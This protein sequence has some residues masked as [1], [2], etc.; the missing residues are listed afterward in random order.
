MDR[1]FWLVFCKRGKI[2]D[3]SAIHDSSQK[4]V[5]TIAYSLATYHLVPGLREKKYRSTTE[6]FYRYY[7]W[8][9]PACSR[10]SLTP[11]PP[12]G[13]AISRSARSVPH[14]ARYVGSTALR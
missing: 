7:F 4:C 10:L 13:A 11:G 8:S 9:P 6:H 3:C 14:S 2:P 12:T 5:V 1:A